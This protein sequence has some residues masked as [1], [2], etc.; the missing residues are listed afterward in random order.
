MAFSKRSMGSKRSMDSTKS[1]GP[2]RRI[3]LAGLTA[4]LLGGAPSTMLSV[5]AAHAAEADY[6]ACQVQTEAEFRLALTILG[7]D[8][9]EPIID[10]QVDT[11]I[12]QVRGEESWTELVRSL[13]S[14]AKA[15]ELAMAVAE[16]VYRAEAFK[17]A[18]EQA[19]VGLGAEIGKRVE[20]A[21]ADA[22]Q[23]AV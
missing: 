4:L 16:R 11:A 17:T 6:R 9:A 13:G 12:E 21:S 10:K 5:T 7:A 3:G 18:L 23:P 22:A 2:L 1:I 19:V 14:K 15:E 8:A 20:I